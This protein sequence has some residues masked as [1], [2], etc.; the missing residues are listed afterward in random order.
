VLQHLSTILGFIR[1]HPESASPDAV[2]KLN[3]WSSEIM[4]SK[5]DAELA[6]TLI[7][8]KKMSMLEKIRNESMRVGK[9]LGSQAERIDFWNGLIEPL[10]E[11]D[12]L[13]I[14]QY[15]RDPWWDAKVERID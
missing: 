1:Q 5:D 14:F 10:F 7:S 12:G 6:Q 13:I 8:K 11:I 2:F 15:A 9:V 4:L 3:L